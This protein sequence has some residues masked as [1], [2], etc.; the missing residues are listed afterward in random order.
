M[1]AIR[2]I[3]E[4][5]LARIR[6][7]PPKRLRESEKG[8]FGLLA[9]HVNDKRKLAYRISAVFGAAQKPGVS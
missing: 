9:E 1:A 5:E 2:H 8:A 6:A 7:W 3:R 4:P